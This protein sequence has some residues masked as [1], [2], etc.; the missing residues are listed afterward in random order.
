MSEGNL[1]VAEIQEREAVPQIVKRREA[2]ILF[3]SWSYCISC[4]RRYWG[5]DAVLASPTN[6]T[7]FK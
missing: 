6:P 3:S 4:A 7:A 2:K 5:C 1:G